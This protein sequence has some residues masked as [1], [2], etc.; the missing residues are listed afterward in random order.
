[1]GWKMYFCVYARNNISIS[2][3]FIQ[4]LKILKKGQ[5]NFNDFEKGTY[6]QQLTI[7]QKKKKKNGKYKIEAE[8]F[9]VSCKRC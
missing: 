7:D 9:L 8:D 2:D 1:M 5:D 4:V 6:R 3:I